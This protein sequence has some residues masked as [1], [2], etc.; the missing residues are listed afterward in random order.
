MR[1]IAKPLEENKEVKKESLQNV[2]AEQNLELVSD[3]Q[4][5][6]GGFCGPIYLLEVQDKKTQEKF[7][8]VEKTFSGIKG[9]RY[10]IEDAEE[11]GAEKEVR[12]RL[13]LVDKESGE[14]KQVIVD[15]LYNED[16]A[17]KDLAGIPGIPKSYGPVYE[18]IKG[19]ILEQFVDGFDLYFID[20]N[21]NSE[22]EIAAV[23]AKIKETYTQ[24]A[25][26]GYIYNNPVGAT[27]MVEKDTAQPY[28]IDWY[29]HSM[30][31]IDSDGPVK[32]KF[33]A[34][35]MAIDEREKWMIDSFRAKQKSKKTV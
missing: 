11:A 6:S 19:S 28:F 32:E 2:L 26:K 14:I 10:I 7:Q 27:I 23:F 25:K 24:A 16:R 9:E 21:V 30:G 4:T 33:E 18:G 17:L 31:S 29:N 34:G 13:G 22:Q 15:W 35:L 8:V 3:R 1:E 20:D 5:L 12:S